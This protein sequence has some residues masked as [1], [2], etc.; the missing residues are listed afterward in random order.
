MQVEQQDFF[1]DWRRSRQSPPVR[2]FSFIL[3]K[4]IRFYQRYISFMLPPSCRF[5]PTCSSYTIEAFQKKSFPR[6]LYLSARRI[7][8][9]NPFC[10]GGYD[11]LPDD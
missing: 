11:P 5:E 10:K 9:C 3:I 1:S 2:V 6:A 8:R 7:L 4:L